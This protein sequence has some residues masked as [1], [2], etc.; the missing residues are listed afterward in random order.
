MGWFGSSLNNLKRLI[1]NVEDALRLFQ[2]GA[3]LEENSILSESL[4][5]WG[6]RKFWHWGNS[7]IGTV[8]I[9]SIFASALIFI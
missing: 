3:Y 2:K 8:F 6:E 5:R 4:K 7:I 1:V 9:C